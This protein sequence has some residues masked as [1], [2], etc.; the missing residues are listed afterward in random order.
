METSLQASATPSCLLCFYSS[1]PR[2]VSFSAHPSLVFV[3]HKLAVE[4]TIQFVLLLSAFPFTFSA[5]EEQLNPLRT[6]AQCTLR[7]NSKQ[8]T[9]GWLSHHG[10]GECQSG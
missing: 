2:I 10:D 5:P 8:I 9:T 3:T 7:G 1:H 6:L 4:T